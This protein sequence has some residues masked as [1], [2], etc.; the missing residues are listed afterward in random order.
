[1]ARKKTIYAWAARDKGSKKSYMYRLK[2]RFCQ[3]DGCF[4]DRPGENWGYELP[5]ITLKPGELRK[6]KITLIPVE[7]Y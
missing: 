6:I 7:K 4:D 1:M 5:G 3:D 2:P